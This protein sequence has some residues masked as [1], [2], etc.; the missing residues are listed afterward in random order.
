M[1]REGG[2]VK[3]IFGGVSGA[4]RTVRGMYCA[5]CRIGAS[6]DT[7]LRSTSKYKECHLLAVCAGG[8]IF[9][10]SLLFGDFSS[11]YHSTVLRYVPPTAVLKIGMITVPVWVL[12]NTPEY[13]N[14][15]TCA[16]DDIRTVLCIECSNHE[17][18]CHPISPDGPSLF[19]NACK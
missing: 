4:H 3:L 11:L 16:A 13:D 14:M 19:T 5:C 7:F 17:R 1:G 6:L 18:M 2:G 15:R 10:V 9:R 12:Y 8:I